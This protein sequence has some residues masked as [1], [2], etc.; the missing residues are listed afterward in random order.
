[1]KHLGIFTVVSLMVFSAGAQ[2]VKDVQPGGKGSLSGSIGDLRKKDGKVLEAPAVPGP[3]GINYVAEVVNTMH[4]PASA[5]L[6]R[7]Q[8]LTFGV[9]MATDRNDL[10]ASISLY[11]FKRKRWEKSEEL[12]IGLDYS[13]H[14]ITETDIKRFVDPDTRE[15][16]LRIVAEGS[17][18]KFSLTV[19]RVAFKGKLQREQTAHQKAR[20]DAEAT[21][22]TRFKVYQ[23]SASGTLSSRISDLSSKREQNSAA[24]AARAPSNKGALKESMENLKKRRNNKGGKRRKR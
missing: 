24:P 23:A 22:D 8:S 10:E 11:D 17:R 5:P 19:D 7:L 9:A 21:D 18:E 13:D 3:A 16:K 14:M 6:D 1:M 15:I 2:Y 12:A 20:E 4:V